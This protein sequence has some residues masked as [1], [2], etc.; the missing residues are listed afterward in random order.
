MTGPGGGYPTDPH[1]P[2]EVTVRL[3]GRPLPPPPGGPG[4][5]WPRPVPPQRGPSRV[6]WLA[7]GA[8]V[9]AAISVTTAVVVSVR[10]DGGDQPSAAATGGED[11][12][13][14]AGG[15][16]GAAADPSAG[17]DAPAL[18]DVAGLEAVLPPSGDLLSYLG[19]PA[20]QEVRRF[21]RTIN[22][23]YAT[24]VH[25]CG[26]VANPYD[27]SA[28]RGSGY[29]S[30]RYSF[31]RDPIDQD[32]PWNQRVWAGGVIFHTADAAK[33]MYTKLKG[34]FESCAGRTVNLK[35]AD[36]DFDVFWAVG[37]ATTDG[38]GVTSVL[39]FEEGADSWRCAH[40]VAQRSNA[41]IEV[42]DCKHGATTERGVGLVKQMLAK[43][44]TPQ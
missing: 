42:V 26:P 12:A 43:I 44:A 20:D 37:P 17:A 2:D 15:G 36:Q 30:V 39:N 5:G 31:V 11:P 19:L 38:D 1:R 40:A 4:P 22:L 3:P 14:E 41:L 18:L 16:E 6:K 9:L 29:T 35:T 13:D 25:N 10:S 33:A 28:Y 27:G 32:A 34:T 21:E 24:D 8:A 23:D 7:V